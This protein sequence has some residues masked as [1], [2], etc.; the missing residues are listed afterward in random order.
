MNKIKLRNKEV[1][2]IDHEMAEDE[3]IRRLLN[4]DQLAS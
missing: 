2:E 3:W 4:G 1:V